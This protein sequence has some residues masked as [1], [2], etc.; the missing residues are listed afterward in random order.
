MKRQRGRGGRKPGGG[1]HQPNR[2]FESTGPDVKIRGPAAHIYEKYLQ[3][4]RDAHSAGDRVMAENYMQH[5]EHYYR[6][7]RAMQP[8]HLPQPQFE[9]RFEQT[10]D[11]EAEDEPGDETQGEGEPAE[12]AE[13]AEGNGPAYAGGQHQQ[14]RRERNEFRREPR[15]EGAA[16]EGEARE[17]RGE[18]EDGEGGF[19]GRRRRRG[20][21]RPEGER[22][23]GERG[24][25]SAGGG[26]G[27][28]E[29]FGDAAPSFLVG[30]E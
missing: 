27:P 2:S 21:F 7:L 11:F 20:R 23:E 5:A 3:L 25:A 28:V 29:G 1:G 4:S 6:I 22:R 16:G 17:F 12:V 14:P 8:Q 9:Q 30:G 13:A 10:F 26:D 18:G 24:P 19:R 15:P